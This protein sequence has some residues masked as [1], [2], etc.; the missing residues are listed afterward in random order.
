MARGGKYLKRIPKPG[1]GF[2]YVYSHAQAKRHEPGMKEEPKEYH[3]AHR[4]HHSGRAAHYAEQ[5]KAHTAAAKAMD[6][7]KGKFGADYWKKSAKHSADKAIHHKTAAAEHKR[8]SDEIVQ[9]QS[10]K[11]DPRTHGKPLF[12]G[13]PEKK[14]VKRTPTKSA[15]P[16]FKGDFFSDLVSRF[17]K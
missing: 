6:G 15:G 16:L 7:Q 1:G 10:G 17:Y 2:T 8:L 11:K 3:D 5:A 12:A 13:Q 9:K 14:P 4:E